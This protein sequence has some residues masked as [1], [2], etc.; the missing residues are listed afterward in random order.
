MP[1]SSL[2]FFPLRVLRVTEKQLKSDI[3]LANKTGH[4]DLL[5]TESI[6]GSTRVR[7]ELKQLPIA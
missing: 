1:Q 2:T 4:F 3:S 5:I 7:D 6:L